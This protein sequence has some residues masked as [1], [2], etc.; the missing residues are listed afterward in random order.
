MCCLIH[1]GV[2]ILGTV[3]KLETALIIYTQPKMG[4]KE[5]LAR[6]DKASQAI[7]NF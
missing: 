6:A 1:Y 7:S 3:V 2:D 4:T 5:T